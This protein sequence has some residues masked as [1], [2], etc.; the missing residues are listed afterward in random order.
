MISA[1]LFPRLNAQNHHITS[2]PTT[3]YNCI[4]WAAGDTTNWWQPGI[5]WPFPTDPLDDSLTE[6]TRVFESL[7]YEKCSDGLIEVGHEKVGLYGIGDCYTHAARQL[8]SGKWTSKLGNEDDI[9][10]DSPD[11]VAGGI[12]GDVMQFMKRKTDQST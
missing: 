8:A 2:P 1:S 7:G 4:A 6:L 10:H 9:E 3:T 5:Y 12:Y 11:V